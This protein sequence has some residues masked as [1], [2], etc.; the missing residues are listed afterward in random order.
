MKRTLLADHLSLLTNTALQYA[1]AAHVNNELAMHQ[2]EFYDSR[3][4]D[5]AY[6]QGIRNLQ[7][8]YVPCCVQQWDPANQRTLIERFTSSTSTFGQCVD[9]RI[10]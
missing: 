7:I 10:H 8:E 5:F 3:V 6:D 4:N 2:A 1:K 9:A